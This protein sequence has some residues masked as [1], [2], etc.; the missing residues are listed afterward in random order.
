MPFAIDFYPRCTHHVFLSH[1]GADRK[2]LVWPVY[3]RLKSRGVEVW[4]DQHDFEYG[5]DSLVALDE[6]VLNCRHVVFFLT[7]AML[8][9]P[10][11]WCPVELAYADLVQR[12]LRTPGLD[13]VNVVLPLKFVSDESLKPTVWRTLD[14]SGQSYNPTKHP[15]AVG[16]ATTAI[17]R[18]LRSGEALAKQRDIRSKRDDEFKLA[19][20]SIP[21]LRDRVTKFHPRRL[22]AESDAK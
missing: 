1:S 10:K 8:E 7:Y 2:D 12:N 5:R 22:P 4:L 17:E 9:N 11:G 14:D 18:F 16:W 3:E 20:E 6:G 15:D 19:L 21:G 13:L